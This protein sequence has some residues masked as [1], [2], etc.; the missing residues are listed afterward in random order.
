MPVDF[1]PVDFEVKKI[2]SLRLNLLTNASVP[3]MINAW[4]GLRR[5]YSL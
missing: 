3:H 1:G 2:E 5:Y 4:S